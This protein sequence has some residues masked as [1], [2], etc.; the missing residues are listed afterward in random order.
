MYKYVCITLYI[1]NTCVHI[2]S[3]ACPTKKNYMSTTNLLLTRSYKC[4][5]PLVFIDRV[6][7]LTLYIVI[8]WD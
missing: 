4:A 6:D 1:L 7:I 3:T 8:L 5:G 2:L